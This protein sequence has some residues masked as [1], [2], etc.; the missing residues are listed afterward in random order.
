MSGLFAAVI[1]CL[2]GLDTDNNGTPDC[3]DNTESQGGGG[4]S[5]CFIHSLLDEGQGYNPFKQ[6][7]IESDKHKGAV[8]L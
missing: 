6:I 2:N 3:S 8:Q 7:Q 4:G 5:G 1:D